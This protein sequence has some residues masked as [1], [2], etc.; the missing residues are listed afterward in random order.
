MV[1]VA[2]YTETSMASVVDDGSAKAPRRVD[3]GA[4]PGVPLGVGGGED[5]VDEDEGA[6]D[7]GA[8]AVALGVAGRDDV[9]AAAGGLVQAL[10]EA[11]DDAGAADGAEAL[12]HHVE[13]GP[14]EGQL[15]GEEEA[16]GDGRVDV[17]AGDAGGAVD[18]GEDHAAE[19]PGDA[20]DADG[21]ALGGGVVDPHDGEDGDVEEEEGGHE[22][23][24]PGAVEG[25]RLE[26]PWLE[27]RRRRRLLV[28][29]VV[30]A[31]RR[32]ADRL[33]LRELVGSQPD[34]LLLPLHLSTFSLLLLLLL[35]RSSSRW[36]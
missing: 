2:C 9:G 27:Q 4:V 3:A 31:L 22:L 24:D 17:A 29:L 1:A 8:E 11:L 20:L 10:L 19:G 26:L 25:P 28:V 5:G 18:E 21:G 16:E 15:P 30:G 33:P 7:L 14:G 34:I 6:D 13:E 23:G 35:L 32:R 12:H 36:V